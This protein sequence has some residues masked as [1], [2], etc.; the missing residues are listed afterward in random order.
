MTGPTNDPFKGAGLA[1]RTFQV[2]FIIRVHKEFFKYV[3]AFKASEFKDGHYPSPSSSQKH[4]HLW[5]GR[6]RFYNLLLSG[7]SQDAQINGFPN[8]LNAVWSIFETITIEQNKVNWNS[9]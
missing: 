8:R 4:P 1:F 2:H 9:D 3:A 7:T 5:D 6:L